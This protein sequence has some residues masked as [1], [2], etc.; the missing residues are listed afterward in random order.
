MANATKE[1]ARREA[2]QE[3]KFEERDSSARHRPDER[4][5]NDPAEAP[6]SGA[7]DVHAAGATGGGSAVGGL[8]GTNVGDG[9]VENADI[10]A[11]AGSGNFDVGLDADEEP[12]YAG[13]AGGAVGGTPAGKLATGGR[14]DHGL[15]PGG[16]H[17]GDSTIGGDPQRST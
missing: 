8:A 13:S 14:T 12:A 1:Q 15:A 7:G 3:E 6:G 11:A 4:A 9:S 2:L 17:R 16:V 5:P 10:D